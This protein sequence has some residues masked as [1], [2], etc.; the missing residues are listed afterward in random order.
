MEIT[1]KRTEYY[2]VVREYEFI[3][4]ENGEVNYILKDTIKDSRNNYFHSFENRCVYDV[5]FMK[6]WKTEKKLF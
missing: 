1:Y 4:P 2:I 3:R 5:K 6:I